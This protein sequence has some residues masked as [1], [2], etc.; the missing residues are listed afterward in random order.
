MAVPRKSYAEVLTEEARRLLHDL[1]NATSVV[2]TNLAF[3]HEHGGL[4]GEAKDAVN[5]GVA[6]SGAL[7]EK[8]RAL[9]VLIG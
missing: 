5:D 2:T 8:L 3:L 4:T 9:R 1:A 7:V 6:A